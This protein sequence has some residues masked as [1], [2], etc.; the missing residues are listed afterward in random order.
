[1]SFGA[2]VVISARRAAADAG[3]PAAGEGG[4]DGGGRT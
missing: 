4:K 1:M 3:A 2:G